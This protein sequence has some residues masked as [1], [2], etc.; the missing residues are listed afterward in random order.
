MNHTSNNFEENDDRCQCP[1]QQAIPFLDTSCSI[2]KGRIVLDLYNK[3]TDR[4]MYFL[5]TSCHPP[6]Q[7]ENIPFSLAMR[8]NQICTFP[9]TR[10]ERLAEMKE[11][12]LKRDYRPGLVDGAINKA[13][14]IPRNIALK[15]VVKTKQSRRPVA[16]VSWDPRLPPMDKIQQKHW[17]AMSSL[18]P[19]LKEV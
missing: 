4:N 17:R 15:K 9:E 1:D 16:V 3:T 6:H 18:D 5:P 7:Q 10:D 8:I 19:Y 14:N 11:W 2:K 12:L 13:R